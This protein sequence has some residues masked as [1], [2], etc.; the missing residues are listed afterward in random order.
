DQLAQASVLA[1]HGYGVLITD[2]RGHGE[3]DG[4]AMDFGWYGDDDIAGAVS[5][6]SDRPDVDPG[7]IGVVGFSMGGEEAIGAIAVDT[8]IR[9]VV[10]EGAT[11][12]TDADQAWFADVYGVRGRLQ[13]GLEWVEFTLTDLLTAADRPTPLVV[14]AA[15]AQPRPILLI[16]AERVPDERHAAEFIRDGAPDNVTIW[17]VPDAGHTGGYATDPDEW[18]ARV[19]AFLDAALL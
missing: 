7:R 11:V 1:T 10:A 3:S 17:E 15:A 6:L 12:R 4:R 8:R 9:A 2:A 14:A 18:G 13:L 16:T 19:T 5:F